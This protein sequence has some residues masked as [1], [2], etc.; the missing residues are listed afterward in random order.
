MN[1]HPWDG[2]RR[3]LVGWGDGDGGDYGSILHNSMVSSEKENHCCWQ[4]ITN[5]VLLFN[6]D[7]LVGSGCQEGEGGLKEGDK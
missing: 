6:R 7:I 2:M 4:K 5:F 3:V 1:I